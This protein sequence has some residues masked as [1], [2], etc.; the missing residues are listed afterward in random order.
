MDAGCDRLLTAA[1]VTAD[2]LLPKNPENARRSVTYARA[3]LV[4]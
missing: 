3:E 2:D 1:Y 4:P